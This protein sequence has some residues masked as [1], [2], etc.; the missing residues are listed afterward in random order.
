MEWRELQRRLDDLALIVCLGVGWI[1]LIAP[2]VLWRQRLLRIDGP[3]LRTYFWGFIG[4]LVCFLVYYL[5]QQRRLR[6]ARE[7]LTR[8]R[9]RA[10]VAE[11]SAEVGPL[12]EVFDRQYL[13]HVLGRVQQRAD[14][15]QSSATFLLLDIDDF[16]AANSRLGQLVGDRVLSEVGLMLRDLLRGSDTIIRYGGDEFLVVLL[17]TGADQ[18]Q[19]V[20]ERLAKRVERWN[21]EKPVPGFR[22]GLSWAYALYTKGSA[23][24]AILMEAEQRLYTKKNQQLAAG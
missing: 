17:E 5:Q 15:L 22:L 13:D 6:V 23:P 16:K 10:E 24:R 3:H 20:L 9:I 7:G 18:T 2:V 12:P 4:L 8:Q 1:A 21:Q 19:Q 14:H 11:K